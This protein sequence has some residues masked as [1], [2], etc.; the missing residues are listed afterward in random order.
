MVEHLNIDKLVFEDSKTVN[1]YTLDA[2]RNKII[3]G[4][5]LEVLKKIPDESVD[6]VFTDPPYFLQLP[7]KKL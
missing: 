4:D 6:L 3:L 1:Q 2:I 5:A 7:K